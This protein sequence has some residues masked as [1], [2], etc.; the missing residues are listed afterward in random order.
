M[1]NTYLLLA[2][3]DIDK[4]SVI[5]AQYPRMGVAEGNLA[6]LM[7]PE[8][9]HLRET[10]STVFF[11]RR[12]VCPASPPHPPRLSLR[13]LS[14]AAIY[15]GLCLFISYLRV[16]DVER[17]AAVPVKHAATVVTE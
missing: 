7:L 4:G 6:E 16:Q 3:F 1:A 17:P 2:H 5:K 11:L 13:Q 8:G 15:R 12:A 14:E 10:D 9:A